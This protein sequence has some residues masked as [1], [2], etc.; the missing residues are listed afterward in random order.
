MVA[1]HGVGVTGVGKGPVAVEL[2]PS[3]HLHIAPCLPERLLAFLWSIFGAVS[4]D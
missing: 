3:S 2:S 4:A 1:A